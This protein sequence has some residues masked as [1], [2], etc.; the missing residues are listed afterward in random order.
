MEAFTAMLFVEVFWTISHV[1]VESVSV[2]W[3]PSRSL[4]SEADVMNVVLN[5]YKN[6]RPSQKD[7]S[8]NGGWREREKKR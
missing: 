5:L 2:L 1:H 8:G 3:R 7:R 4:S 6:F